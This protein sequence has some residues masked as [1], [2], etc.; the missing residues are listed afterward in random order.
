MTG[1]NG[2]ATLGTMKKR[3]KPK[4]ERQ[5]PRIRFRVT[6]DE[7]A[8]LEAGAAKAHLEVSAWIRATMLREAEKA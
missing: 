6:E 2:V 5:Q 8:N 7:K 1:G 3:R 4:A